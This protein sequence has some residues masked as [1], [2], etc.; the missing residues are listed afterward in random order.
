M[1]AEVQKQQL[2]GEGG[3]EGGRVCNVHGGRQLHRRP[4]HQWSVQQQVL[5]S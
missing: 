2:L 5:N 4:P 3:M 1:P